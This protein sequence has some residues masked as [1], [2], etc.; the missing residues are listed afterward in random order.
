MKNEL[1]TLHTSD[2]ISVLTVKNFIF[3]T[4]YRFKIKNIIEIALVQINN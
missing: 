4:E 2:R 3:F 1:V